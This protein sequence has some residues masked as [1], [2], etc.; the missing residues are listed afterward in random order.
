M[1]KA[2]YKMLLGFNLEYRVFKMF[3]AVL[4]F[5]IAIAGLALMGVNPIDLFGLHNVPTHLVVFLGATIA[6][7]WGILADAS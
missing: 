3:K 1:A 5:L 7:V 6:V 4:F 2:F